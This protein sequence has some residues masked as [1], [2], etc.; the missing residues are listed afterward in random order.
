MS[1]PS[2]SSMLVKAR[3]S[4]PRL[5]A[6]SAAS[7]VASGLTPSWLLEESA[8]AAPGP[9][10]ITLKL[11]LLPPALLIAALRPPPVE[12]GCGAGAASPMSLAMQAPDAKELGGTTLPSCCCCSPGRGLQTGRVEAAGM[13]MNHGCKHTG[14]P[15]RVR[16]D[17]AHVPRQGCP[18]LNTCGFHKAPGGDIPGTHGNVMNNQT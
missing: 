11:A 5:S 3:R 4:P 10:A 13:R 6:A 16:H 9:E 7:T 1:W 17:T 15:R 12:R 18:V 2:S 8:S 14:L